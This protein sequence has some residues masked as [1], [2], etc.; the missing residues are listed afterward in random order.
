MLICASLLAMLGIWPILRLQLGKPEQTE[1]KGLR[2]FHPYLLR[3][4]PAFA[5]WSFVTGSFIPFAPMFFE[6][7]VGMSL[8]HVGIVFSASQLAQ[9]F[10]VLVAPLLYR[11]AGS[12]AGII[13]AQLLAGGAMVALCFGQIRPLRTRRLSA[14]HCGSIC[15]ES[16][17]LRPSDE[18]PARRGP[19]QCFRSAEHYR[20]SGAGRFRWNNRIPDCAL[21][22]F[23]RLWGQCGSGPDGRGHLVCIS[24]SEELID[25]R[26]NSGH[27]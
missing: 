25:R 20:R 13:C 21:R 4:L 15:R 26:R 5:I 6:K 3:F 16:G 10:A 12:V 14:F 24:L 8:Q 22:I 1:R 18:P 23:N 19:Q 11:R 7:H 27:S 17:I 2:A 9:V